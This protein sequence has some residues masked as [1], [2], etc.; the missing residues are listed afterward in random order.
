MTSYVFWPFWPTYH[1]QWCLPY[2]VKY[3]EAFLDP[4]PTL[5]LDII[6]GRSLMKKMF[7][8]KSSWNSELDTAWLSLICWPH[9]VSKQQKRRRKTKEGEEQPSCKK[10][11]EKVMSA[12]NLLVLEN[13]AKTEILPLFCWLHYLDTLTAQSWFGHV[14]NCH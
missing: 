6:Y 13:R 1:A 9:R 4:F 2:N 14:E 5:K 11:D 7:F 10:A 8:H 3:L 12:I